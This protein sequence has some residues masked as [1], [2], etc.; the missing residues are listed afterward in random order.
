MRPLEK[1]QG[2]GHL[3]RRAVRSLQSGLSAK[4]REKWACFAYF[5]VRFGGISLHSRLHGGEGGISNPRYRSE[6]NDSRCSRKLERIDLL[7][8]DRRP[9]IVVA[10][11]QISAVPSPIE[12]QVTGDSCGGRDSRVLAI[13]LSRALTDQKLGS[14]LQ[15]EEDLAILALFLRNSGPQLRRKAGFPCLAILSAQALSAGRLLRLSPRGHVNEESLALE[16]TTVQRAF[17]SSCNRF[18][19]G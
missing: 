7:S 5:G 17:H 12:R 9:R 10:R 16:T 19:K 2:S 1:N 15:L 18:L 11:W 4:N 3:R 8:G 6:L 14:I 13:Q